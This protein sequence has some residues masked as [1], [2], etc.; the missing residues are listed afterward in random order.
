MVP[1]GMLPDHTSILASSFYM[2]TVWLS[3]DE[4]VT[5]A[6]IASVGRAAE[7]GALVYGSCHSKRVGLSILSSVW[8]WQGLLIDQLGKIGL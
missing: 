5:R 4:L 2:S 8:A 6:R 1:V 7:I 3:H